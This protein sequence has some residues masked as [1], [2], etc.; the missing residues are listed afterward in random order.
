MIM[1]RTRAAARTVMV[2][3]G[4]LVLVA[5][6]LGFSDV[7][8]AWTGD[9]SLSCGNILGTQTKLDPSLVGEF[10]HQCTEARSRRESGFWKMLVAGL[11]ALAAGGCLLFVSIRRQH[12]AKRRDR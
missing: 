1:S 10:Q 12:E 9:A 3:G 6:W 7:T 4:V 11:F 8:V 5:L 2:V